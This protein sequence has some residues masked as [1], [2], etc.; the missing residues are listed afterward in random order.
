MITPTLK[1]LYIAYPLLPV[2]EESCGGAEQVLVTV[3]REMKRRGH[4]TVVAACRGSD[5]HGELFATG[6][7]P[8]TPDQFE[9]RSAEHN[10]RLLS[11]TRE[12]SAEFDLIH[13]QSGTFWQSLDPNQ[14]LSVPLLVTLHLPRSFYPDH[15]FTRVPPNVVFNCVSE[16]QASAF[17]DVGAVCVQNGINLD[18]YSLGEHKGEYLLWLGRI[19]EEKGAH[20]AIEV[21]QRTGRQLIIAGRV[22][23]FSYHQGYFREKIWPQLD[24]D[25]VVWLESPNLQQ[26]LAVLQNARAVLIPSLVDETSSLVAM[27][28]MACG[29]PVL[30]FR[31]GALPE[32][33]ADGR[34]GFIIDT[35]AGMVGAVEQVGSINAQACRSYVEAHYSAARM[36]DD[37][38]HLYR[39]IATRSNRALAS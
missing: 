37:Y 38:E 13:D 36:T 31:R 4:D 32:V 25:R 35:V 7:T 1:I 18:K 12:R 2:S 20:L 39:R 3:E 26:K 9:L 10:R 17:T 27:E 8:T 19:C 28:A 14:N 16:A 6:E 15:A 33:I 22:Y 21:A 34:T 5:V 30:A 11:F 24:G 23:P 29:T